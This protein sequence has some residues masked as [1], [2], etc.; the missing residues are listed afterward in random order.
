[1]FGCSWRKSWSKRIVLIGR[2]SRFAENAPSRRTR[3]WSRKKSQGLAAFHWKKSLAR[4]PQLRKNS[5][6]LSA[7]KID[8]GKFKIVGR[9]ALALGV[10]TIITS[11]AA[12][13]DT[14]H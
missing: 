13:R 11:C 10:A 2:R 9:H 5:S 12:P 4:P 1:M 8:M 6:D 14:E 7:G 3:G